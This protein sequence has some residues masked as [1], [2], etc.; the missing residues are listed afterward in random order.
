MKS[1]S[2]K[3]RW[4]IRG[5]VLAAMAMTCVA[6]Q[7]S[8]ADKD[9]FERS[10]AHTR[11]VVEKH[12]VISRVEV[13]SLDGNEK[14]TFQHDRYPEVE[15]LHVKG[16]TTYARKKGKAWLKSK[17]WAESG[18]KVTVEEAKGLDVLSS[19]VDLP[20]MKNARQTEEAL[21]GTAVTLLRRERREPTELLYYQVRRA[22]PGPLLDPEFI[23]KKSVRDID[24]KCLL[25]H[26]YGVLWPHV[27]PVKVSVDYNYIEETL[28]EQK[29]REEKNADTRP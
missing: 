6:R 18:T 2:P 17:D 23:F 20:L 25:A 8:A 21:A 4:T 29:K 14:T 16:K 22:K 11:A 19:Y 10:L 26:F 3:R 24:E 12:H 1:T 5:A 15:Q 13:E 28:A 7:L 27:R 9:T